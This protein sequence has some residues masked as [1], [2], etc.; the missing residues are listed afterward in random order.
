[1][2]EYLEDFIIELSIKV[3]WSWL[4]W[5]QGGAEYCALWT[6]KTKATEM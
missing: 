3:N 4:V 6:T 2:R 5:W 1:M